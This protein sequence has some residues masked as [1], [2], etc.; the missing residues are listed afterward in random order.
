[1]RLTILVDNNTLVGKYFA[2]GESG[3]SFFI[4][5]EDKKILLDTGYSDLFIRNAQQMKIDLRVLDSIVLSHGHFDHTWGLSHLIKFH[6]EARMQKLSYQKPTIYAHPW[7]LDSKTV[8]EGSHEIGS[9]LNKEQLGKQ[10]DTCFSKEPIWL[11]DKLVFLGEIPRFFS[12]EGKKP[13]GKRGQEDDFLLDDTGLAYQTQKGLVIIVGCSHSGI[14]NIIE[15][16]KKVCQEDRIVDIVG[17]LHLLKPDPEQL[18]GTLNYLACLKPEKIHPCHCT[19][20]AS[21]I[22]LSEVVSLEEVGAGSILEY[23]K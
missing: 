8:E 17:G 11:T 7:A 14:C 19:D 13:L 10:F 16:A 22:S 9:L 5:T 1:M 3:L 21:K 2:Q 18:Q 20:L 6:S 23:D 4:E 12:F 15:Y